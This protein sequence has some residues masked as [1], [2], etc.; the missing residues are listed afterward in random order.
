MHKHETGVTERAFESTGGFLP[1]TFSATSETSLRALV[2]LYRT[3]LVSNEAVDL[4]R[5]AYTLGCRRSPFPYKTAFSA[6]SRLDLISQM[7]RS[8]SEHTS[9]LG[10]RSVTTLPSILGIFT[11]QGAQ[12]P[13]MGAGLVR[14]SAFVRDIMEE[15][16]CSLASLPA[17]DR[18][19]WTILG[20]L[21]K[22]SGGSRLDEAA[23]AQPVVNAVQIALVALLRRAGVRFHV[24]LGHSSGEIAAAYAAGFISHK[25]AIRIAYYRGLHS[26]LAQG[27]SGQRGGML[28]VGTCL[29]DGEEFCSLGDFQNRIVV[30]F[31]NKRNTLR[32]HRCD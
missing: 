28:A 4:R 20:E 32:R 17:A 31:A 22:E 23:I 14:G 24:I 19:S 25:D 27:S 11:G 30:K 8:I 5:L 10:V 9:A 12:W 1:F 21:E 26:K 6:T 18:P 13:K 7:D 29:E 2:E 15:L 3:Y 16:D